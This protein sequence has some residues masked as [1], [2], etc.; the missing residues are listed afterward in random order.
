MKHLN[1]QTASCSGYPQAYGIMGL[2]DDGHNYFLKNGQIVANLSGISIAQQKSSPQV[3]VD[4]YATALEILLNQTNNPLDPINISHTLMQL[5]EIPDTGLVN[6]L[7]REMQVYEVLRFMKDPAKAQQYGFVAHH[8]NLENVFGTDHYEILSAKK[9]TL[10]ETAITN[11]DGTSFVINSNATQQYGPALWDPAPACNYSS[12]NGIAISAIT[13]HTVQGSY[14]GA[15]SWAQNCNSNVSYHYVIRSSDGQVTQMVNEADKA[16]H[17]GS[18]NPYTIGYEHEGY[19]NDPSWYTDAMYNSSADLSRDIINSGY[20]ISGLNTYFGE[21]SSGLNELNECVQIKGHQHYP[22]QSHTD[23][24]INWDWNR[25]YKLINDPTAY[26]TFTTN[27]GTLFDSGGSQGE[28]SNSERLFWLIQPPNTDYIDLNFTEFEI[29]TNKD[30]LYIYDG[31]SIND[32]LIGAYTGTSIPP[33]TSTG[34]SLLLEFRSDCIDTAIGWEADY[35]ATP[36]DLIPPQSQIVTGNPWQTDDFDVS[37]V[38]TDNMSGVAVPY[39]LVSEKEITENTPKSNGAYG[40]INESFEDGSLLWTNVTGAFSINNG[41]Y[42]LNDTLEQNSN[43]YALVDQNSSQSYL[44]SWTQR[45]EG[46][47]SNQRAGIHFFCDD[48][49]LPNRG[50]SYFVYLRASDLIQIYEVVND[51]WT[52]EENIS[53]PIDT[54][55]DYKC[56]V[57]YDPTTGW[58]RVFIDDEFVGEW[59][60][61][62]PLTDGNS[63]SL[64]S[65]GCHIHYD[66]VKVYQSRGSVVTI[67]AGFNELMS[68]ESEGATPTGFVYSI[69][70]DSSDNWSSQVEETYLL[71]FTSPELFDLNDGPTTD[72][73]TVTTSTLEANWMGQ[74]IHSDIADYEVAIGTL[75]NLD[76][77]IGWNSNGLNTAYAQIIASPVYN[78]VYYISV[79]ATNG[80]GLMDTLTSDGQQYIDDLGLG[81]QNWSHVSVYP[82][83][84]TEFISISG[85]E[86]EYTVTLI[87]A[88]GKICLEQSLASNESISLGA[89]AAGS[90]QLIIR[91]GD[92]FILKPLM[93]R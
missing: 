89:L 31:D 81:T 92:A 83:P 35:Y 33:I 22:N 80:A 43:T 57:Q 93:K 73:D 84:A 87:D 91:S 59:Q 1:N 11:E 70:I 74:D 13:I 85:L 38:D 61:P 42:S 53:F 56:K 68:V 21:S 10:S 23:P 51:V 34:G 79:R 75:P 26:T 20:G 82:N 4:A 8:Y 27:S 16:W 39:Y 14:A 12:R 18:E 54:D 2:H 63:I 36:L 47:A 49:T 24:G 58:I 88:T 5:S 66:D 44:Y 41:A 46:T 55:V 77:V 76:D 69:A 72:I 86:G 50:N 90:Y 67:P 6:I 40:F 45:I 19:V 29:E 52:L 71:D 78:E 7:A 62:T 48:A 30:Y 17:V 60:D 28:Y 9:I 3:Q 64:R 25:Y 15:I 65:G 32:P 37:F